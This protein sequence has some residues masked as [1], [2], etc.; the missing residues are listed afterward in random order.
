MR[1]LVHEDDR[2]LL[3]G[4]SELCGKEITEE[5][6]RA[7]DESAAYPHEV[8][9]TLA[10]QG[11]S[12]LVVPE[13]HGGATTS[14]LTLAAVHEELSAHSLAVGQAYFSMWVLGAE[15]VARLGTPEQKNH[16]LPRVLSGESRIAFAMTEPSAGSDAAALQ[17]RATVTDQG[18]VLSG[19][20]VFITGAAVSDLIIVACRTGGDRSAISLLLVDPRQ[21]GVSIRKLSKIGLRSIDLCEVFLDDVEV[22]R[23]QLLGDLHGGWGHMRPGLAR[24]R[25]LLAAISAGGLRDVWQQSVAYATERTSFGRRIGDQQMIAKK[26]VDMQISLEA[27]YG[28]IRTAAEQF[29]AGHPAAATTASMAKV[30]ASEAYATATREGIQIF[31]GYGFTDEYP[32]SRHYRDCKYLEI[33]GGTSE[34]QRIIVAR[35]MGLKP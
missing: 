33:G 7:L 32:V 6:M 20:K 27:S 8:M 23:D 29:D 17:S 26:L 19:Q 2:D 22:P 15:Y 34:I 28:L 12:S 31:G 16:W 1:D 4:L 10:Q 30:F 14:S 21:A 11:W 24:E 35:A 13:Q 9:N 25:L 18:F 3:V 5:R